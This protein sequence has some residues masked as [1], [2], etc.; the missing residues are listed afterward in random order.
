MSP[1]QIKDLLA[2]AKNGQTEALRIVDFAFEQVIREGTP[3]EVEEVLEIVGQF[4]IDA[5]LPPPVP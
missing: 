2:S 1:L 5:S 4:L 3:V